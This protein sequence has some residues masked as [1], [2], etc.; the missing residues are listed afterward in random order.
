MEHMLSRRAL[1]ING[2]RTLGAAALVS[3]F[4]VL[5][6]MAQTTGGNEPYKALVCIFL[7]GGNDAFNMIVPIEDAPYTD[8]LHARRDLALPRAGV[9]A[10]LPIFSQNGT[11]DRYGLH[12][13]L[14]NLHP[15][16]E[17][18][19]MAVLCN[20]GTLTYPISSPSEYRS[21]P[22]LRPREL[23][24]H[25]YQ[26]DTWQHL[27]MEEGWGNGIARILEQRAINPS[28]TIPF[29]VNV[30]GGASIYVAGSAPYITLPFGSQLGRLTLKG[31]T[32]S[33]QDQARLNALREIYRIPH[34]DPVVRAV[35]TRTD[36]AISDG[37]TAS[38]ILSTTTLNTVFPETG[39]GRQL[40]Q[41]ALMIKSRDVLGANKRQMFFASI[42]GFDTHDIQ[43][44]THS[45][46]MRQLG[47]ALA[48]FYAATVEIGVE[49][50]VTAFTLSEFGRTVQNSTGGTDHAWGSNAVI[51]GGGVR[52]GQFY[53]TYP[54]LVLGGPD[55]IETGGNARGRILPKI[56]VDQYA[57]TLAKWFG[58]SS[59]EIAAVLPYL[60]RFSPDDLGFMA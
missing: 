36:K 40:K 14:N 35:S 3:R 17:A 33:T 55:D 52:G 19:K 58:L 42:G 44:S 27:G 31:F 30:A 50:S 45:R 34:P 1:L 2:A 4:G 13:E 32:S 24:A 20:V 23:F 7:N 47:D 5:S 22:G 18:G 37:Q 29:L 57:G 16:Y 54:S 28:P 10:L 9:G 43:L 51:V 12:P 11:G 46:L 53:G 49:N 39:I 59:T 26:I 41:A 48:A 21:R 56:A 60:S 6:A 15:L 38:E 8:Y 25:D